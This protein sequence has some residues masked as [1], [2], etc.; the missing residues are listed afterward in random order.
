MLSVKEINDHKKFEVL[1][2][3][4][5]DLLSQSEDDNVFLTWEW[6]YTWWQHFKDGKE[7]FILEVRDQHGLLIGIAP[8]YVTPV[9]LLKLFSVRE[10][11]WLGF[12]EMVH[13]DYL[14]FI[15]RKGYENDA[16]TEIFKYL[17]SVQN[18]WDIINLTDLSENLSVTKHLA[19][20]IEDRRYQYKETPCATCVYAVLPQSW[21]TYFKKL[22]KTLRYNIRMSHS[23]LNENFKVKFFS[24]NRSDSLDVGIEVLAQL[25]HKRWKS[26]GINHSFT[27]DRENGFHK[28]IATRLYDKKMLRLYCLCLND[29]I[30]AMQYIFSCGNKFYYFQ[31]GF[32]PKYSRYSVGTALQAYTLQE[33]IKEGIKE[34]DFLRGWH[35]YKYDWARSERKTINLRAKNSKFISS[36]YWWHSFSLPELKEKV[37]TLYANNF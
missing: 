7:L 15:I 5:N 35:R 11:R 4:W 22:K 18:R 37:K 6:A 10:I 19:A 30:V 3:E 13:P 2:T 32:D 27:S 17:A 21:E 29:E 16:L 25:H 24:W 23:R 1:S 12:G 36:V 14:N 31:S 33:A 28:D 8:F 34:F 9:R 20:Q 26:Q